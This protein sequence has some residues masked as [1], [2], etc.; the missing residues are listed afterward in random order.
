PVAVRRAQEHRLEPA[1]QGAADRTLL[2]HVAVRQRG[3]DAWVWR[4]AGRGLRVLC[5]ERG[6]RVVGGVPPHR[7]PPRALPNPVGGCRGHPVS[8]SGISRSTWNLGGGTAIWT[9]ALIVATGR[10]MFPIAMPTDRPNLE[11]IRP[12]ICSAARVVAR[13]GAPLTACNVCDEIVSGFG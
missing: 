6:G 9:S 1:D 5:Q 11:W 4:G 7:R 12:W 13:I 8:A 3:L 10:L 2:L